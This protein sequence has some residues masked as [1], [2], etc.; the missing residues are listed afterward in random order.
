M[1][2]GMFFGFGV[3]AVLAMCTSAISVT[4][5]RILRLTRKSLVS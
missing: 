4:L 1:T 5:D 3:A 2:L